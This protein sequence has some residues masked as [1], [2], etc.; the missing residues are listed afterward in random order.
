MKHLVWFRNDLRTLDNPA[1]YHACH[2]HRGEV[3]ACYL[4]SR[5]TVKRHSLGPAK[6]GFIEQH[7]ALLGASLSELGIPL[8]VLAVD[9][10]G[11]IASAL[12]KHCKQLEI[13]RL[14]YNAEYPLDEA[15][16][17]QQVT[18]H[19]RDAKIDV[20]RYHDRVIV[21][22]GM[23]K[24]GQGEMYRV[25]TPFMKQWVKTVSGAQLSVY[26]T[27][28]QRSMPQGVKPAAKSAI[29][30]LFEG[31]PRRDLSSYWPAGEEVALQRLSEF[32]KHD[33][34]K[35]QDRRDLPAEEGTSRLS[36]YLAVGA[37]SPK[38]C[39]LAVNARGSWLENESLRTWVNE[40]IW[41]EFYTHI[42]AA[43]PELSRHQPMQAH[44]RN[45]PWS[46]DKKAFQRWCEGKTGIPIVDAAMRQLNQTG[47]M[48]NR[49]RM[50]SAMFLTKNLRIHWRWGEEYFMQQLID[51]DF[52]SNNGGWQWCASTGTDAAPYF[53]IMNPVT[54][55][56][57]FD[58][59]GK[60]IRH[61]VP[62]LATVN[63][64]HIHQAPDVADYPRPM[65]DLKASRRETI[66][67]FQTLQSERQEA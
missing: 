38:Q 46:D 24:N 49:L 9:H 39:F 44:T 45:F 51:A 16:R 23:L 57:K 35:Y 37:I 40:L 29:K 15:R 14:F 63:G 54:Q 41:R 65:V 20:N 32:A 3:Y 31:A 27:P 6:L 5:D 59:E 47:W 28:Q 64:R 58:P 66:E 52:A 33:L 22:P 42:I 8:Q 11:E 1:L 4:F 18:R 56:Q 53:R 50:I 43:F 26:P 30:R 34:S 55:S 7:L 61:F 62:E 60:F 13:A 25:Y 12:L 10:Q 19:L 48:H 17:D 21:P 36:P 2:Q 67:L